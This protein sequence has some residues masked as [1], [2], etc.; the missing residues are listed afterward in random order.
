MYR[1]NINPSSA[2]ESDYSA[3]ID[4]LKQKHVEK[5]ILAYIKKVIRNSAGGYCCIR[6]EV[7][8]KALGIRK[9]AV[10]DGCRNIAQRGELVRIPVNN[11]NRKNPKYYYFL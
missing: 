7:I 6:Q 3:L 8:R 2:D 9:Q 5:R 10:S 1:E 4:D 11:K